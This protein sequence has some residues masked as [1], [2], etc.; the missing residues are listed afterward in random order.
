MRAVVNHV[1]VCCAFSM[2]LRKV[3]RVGPPKDL[4]D[5]TETDGTYSTSQ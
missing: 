4:N 3:G 5:L 2:K 1:Y